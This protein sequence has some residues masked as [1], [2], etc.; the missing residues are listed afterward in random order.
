M[1]NTLH[2]EELPSLHVLTTE[3]AQLL[4][5]APETIRYWERTGRLPAQ[6]T[7]RG[8]RLFSRTDVM[9]LRQQRQ[10]A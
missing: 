1:N 8:V 6:K 4:G 7:S 3:A 10:G 5:V 9:R 2:G